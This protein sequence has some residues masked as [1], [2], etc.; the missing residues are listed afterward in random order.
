MTGIPPCKATVGDSQFR[1]IR[2]F[3]LRPMW[4][5]AAISRTGTWSRDIPPDEVRTQHRRPTAPHIGADPQVIAPALASLLDDAAGKVV[6]TLAVSAD[7]DR[8]LIIP[9]HHLPV[10]VVE[11]DR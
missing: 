1:Y 5:L 9:S 7:M 2:R 4:R 10:F 11:P 8:T 6:I 3:A